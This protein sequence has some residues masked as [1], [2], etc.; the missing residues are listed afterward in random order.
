M[1]ARGSCEQCGAADH[2][3]SIEDDRSAC[4]DHNQCAAGE[5]SNWESL[6][7][8]NK[9]ASSCEPC[10]GVTEYSDALSYGPCSTFSVPVSGAQIKT[11][12]SATTD[13]VMECK[14]GFEGDAAENP[15]A[16]TSCVAD[17]TFAAAPG[18]TACADVRATVG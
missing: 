15:T 14:A 5:G 8:Q 1:R 3:Y 2:E 16:C 18:A 17:S 13:H 6:P 12:G 9:A 11:A 7:E 4:A 10:D